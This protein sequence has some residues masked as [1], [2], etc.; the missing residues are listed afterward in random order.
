MD[1]KYTVCKFL[2]EKQWLSPRNG[3][4]LYKNLVKTGNPPSFP[5]TTDFFGL[6]YRG[7]LSNSIDYHIYYYGA[8]EKPLLFFL[9][10]VMKATVDDGKGVFL[11]IGAN[12]GQ[13][14][15]FMSSYAHQVHAFEPY[16]QVRSRFELHVE[17]NQL[18]NVTIHPL[19]LSN[20]NDRIPFFAPAG[21]N[22]G[23]GSFDSDSTD[24]GNEYLGELEVMVGD[25]YL[26]RHGIDRVDL[27]KIDVEGFEKL[28]I[29]GLKHTLEQYQP[30]LVMEISYGS[31]SSFEDENDLRGAL[32]AGY[33]LFNFDKRKPDGSKDRRNESKAR[34]TGGYA[35]VPFRFGSTGQQDDIIACPQQTLAKLPRLND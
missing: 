26:L 28:V 35:L 30:V 18:E 9:R 29:Q 16:E 14:A 20:K 7:D 3:R 12:V 15:L 25:D 8:F 34:R 11:D 5:F 32:P 4:L 31:V 27:V 10:D 1:L 19:G 2:W 17:R 21:N 13:H 24:R 33:Q 6:E 22:L 23:I